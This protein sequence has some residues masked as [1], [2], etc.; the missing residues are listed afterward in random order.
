MTPPEDL[1]VG[2]GT[3]LSQE[4]TAKTVGP[5]TSAK[6]FRPVVVLGYR[7]LFNLRP[8]HYRPSFHLTK[9]PL[10]VAAMNVMPWE[11]SSFNGLAFPVSPSEL[12]ALDHRERYYERIQV[13]V[14]AF[15]SRE[16]LGDAWVYSASP[17][18]PAV[19]PP[20]SELRPQWE[21][22]VLARAGAYA[23]GQAFGK[24]FDDTTFL[25]DGSTLAVEAYRA[26]LQP[27]TQP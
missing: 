17:E 26:Y 23:K 15:P 21:D 6:T 1:L 11:G 22:L 24:M 9:E 25:A 2:Y 3:L 10:E 27:P 13:Q 19:F 12:E 4:S 5:S 8:D 7:R 14:L 18:A 20:E 16:P